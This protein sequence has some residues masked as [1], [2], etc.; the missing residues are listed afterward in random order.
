MRRDAGQGPALAHRFARAAQIERLQVA[1]PAVDRTEVVERSA[2]AEILALD[3]GDR[4]SALRR[5]VRDREAVNAAADDQDVER[6]GRQAAEGTHQSL[7]A[8][9]RNDAAHAR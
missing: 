2:A 7:L 4:E 9:R 6:P 8:R 5:V 1:Q 3:E